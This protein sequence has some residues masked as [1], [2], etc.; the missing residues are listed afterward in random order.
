MKFVIRAYKAYS[1]GARLLADK[2]GA[3]IVKDRGSKFKYNPNR[4]TVIN[5]GGSH[6]SHG[7]RGD[8]FINPVRYVKIASNKLHFFQAMFANNDEHVDHYVPIPL[9]TTDKLVAQQW[10]NS[11]KK[12]CARA[13]LTGNSGAGLTV[14]RLGDVLPDVPMY[15]MYVP[16]TAEYRVHIFNH[17]GG[18]YDTRVVKKKL[19]HDAPADRNKFIRNHEN[20]YV[21]SLDTGPLP[22]CVITAAKNALI[23]SD[24]HFG[25]VDI[26]YNEKTNTC[27]VYEINTAP[28]IEGS[29]V[30]WYAERFKHKEFIF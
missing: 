2:L 18:E 30:D 9:F 15:V 21:F 10:L 20:G 28:G 17:F 1:E 29:T 19:K 11:G 16:K 23:L 5:W 27:V 13:T 22:E 7:I 3:I 12:V 14:H 6:E 25:A 26:G 24:L 8:F 4:H